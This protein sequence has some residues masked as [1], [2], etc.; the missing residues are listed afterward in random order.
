MMVMLLTLSNVARSTSLLTTLKTM[1]IDQSNTTIAAQ[2]ASLQTHV[3]DIDIM[4]NKIWLGLLLALIVMVLILF[5]LN[6]L[7]FACIWSLHQRRHIGTTLHADDE[8]DEDEPIIQQDA[9][10]PP[11]YLDHRPPGGF[12]ELKNQ[13]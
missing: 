6:V 8:D 4:N 11:S 2:I 7:M 3:N 9:I 5:F 13:I 12:S 1:Y 10:I